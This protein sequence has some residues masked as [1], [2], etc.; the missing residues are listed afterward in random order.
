MNPPQV[1]DGSS[2]GRGFD[3]ASFGGTAASINGSTA[4]TQL[5][6]KPCV[7]ELDHI[8][9]RFGGV[10]GL[11]GVSLRVSEGEVCGLIGP[12]GAGKTTLF[13]VISGMRTPQ[14]GSVTMDG[15][16]VTGLS[17]AK[18]AREG[19][20]RTFQRVQTFGWLS[21][22]DN[23]LTAL[24]WRGGGGGLI[25]DLL[26]LPS[27]RRPERQRRERVDHVLEL[28]GLTE[29]RKAAAGSLPIGQ[30][31][32][33]EFGR[34][35][36]ETPRLLLLDEPT[37]GLEEAEVDRL[38]QSMRALLGE[39]PCAVILVEHDMHFVMAECSPIVVLDQGRVLCS[40]SPEEVRTNQEVQTAYLG[41]IKGMHGAAAVQTNAI[42]KNREGI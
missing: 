9:V 17:A 7:L 13:D 36:I 30:A 32:M 31:R 27:R 18:R 34:A 24:E 16:N 22:E 1:D 37:S 15:V 12:N 14:E 19:I 33:V 3:G 26:A 6:T 8:G 40:G 42:S 38:A 4:S 41:D 10:I 2:D 11:D 21:V 25:A 20:R 39:H 23:L 28:C 5:A 35:I 29:I